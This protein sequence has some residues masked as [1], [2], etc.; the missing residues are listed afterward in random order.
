MVLKLK[1]VR[2]CPD[3]QLGSPTIFRCDKTVNDK[4]VA[5]TNSF[6][7]ATEEELRSGAKKARIFD[8]QKN[9]KE[10]RFTIDTEEG[11]GLGKKQAAFLD[12]LK[13][14]PRLT[15]PVGSPE[16]ILVNENE[17]IIKS[18]QTI[19]TQI[20][21]AN[22]VNSLGTEIYDLCHYLGVNV[23][24][25]TIEDIYNMLL[26][27]KTGLVFYGTYLKDGKVLPLLEKVYSYSADE[28]AILYVTCNKA[29]L[30]EIIK[31]EQGMFYFN[32]NMIGSTEQDVYSFFKNNVKLWDNLVVSVQENEQTLYNIVSADLWKTSA[33]I[34]NSLESE[35]IIDATK[36]DAKAV[37]AIRDEAKALNV[38]AWWITNPDTLLLKIAE[39][40]KL[41]EDKA[42][43]KASK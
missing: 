32:T 18:V 22:K 43:K 27:F 1:L 41:N 25:K 15:K 6:E 20:A 14:H 37:Q 19:Q 31:K 42:A 23:A 12:W 35:E 8:F 24:G 11:N 17:E 5:Y 10:V 2:N 13:V 7:L 34:S 28:E 3:A 21:V 40:K 9:V 4:M 39:R 26:N 33:V 30:L 38:P 29:I 36:R 16:F